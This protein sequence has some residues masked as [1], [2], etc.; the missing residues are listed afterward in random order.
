ML[1][2]VVIAAA[3]TLP[4]AA[5][6]IAGNLRLPS[7][8]IVRA[9]GLHPGQTAEIGDLD[10]AARVLFDTGLFTSVNYRYDSVPATDPPT[11]TISFQVTEDTA[12]T[13]VRIEI[14][15]ID[16]AVVWRDLASSEPLVTR[17]MPHNDRAGEF[18][19]RAVEH[20]LEKMNRHEKIVIAE[21]VALGS[22]RMDT[23]LVPA[24]PP[25]VGDVR[26]EGA[27]AIT[28]AAL[29]DAVA[30]L[31]VGNRYSE[32]EFRQ[33]LD[34][35]VRP[36]YEDRGYLKVEFP[37]LRLTPAG[38]DLAVDVQVAE[39]SPWTLGMIALAGDHLPDEA[40]RKAAALWDVHT[41]DW[42][43]IM[44][45]IARMEK[46]LRRDGYLNVTSKPV[47][48]YR[49]DGR[50][51]DLRIEFNK[52]TQFVFG[53]LKIGGLNAHDRELAE[54]L[55]RIKPGEPLDQPYL[56]DYVKQCLDFL[57]NSVKTFDSKMTLR[58]GT[59]LMDLTLNFQ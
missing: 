37:A 29:R 20:V 36:L 17:R 24:N 52:G 47:R 58:P 51:V 55:F 4:V 35:N 45:G 1:L 14:A 38:A 15:G 8:A 30:R 26:F 10:A 6:N 50:T 34:L 21:S 49:D 43:L 5:V 59:N 13:D 19:C 40:M 46:V 53:S 28:A 54:K 42:K 39:G 27:H 25:K 56:E 12:D 31:V 7:A 23:T 2:P 18:Y 41:A 16:E 11:Y 57:G 48:L 9:T 3:Q 22:R 33:V 44:E 32:R